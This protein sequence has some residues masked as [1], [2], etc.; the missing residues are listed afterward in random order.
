MAADPVRRGGGHGGVGLVREGG[1]FGVVDGSIRQVFEVY[2][3]L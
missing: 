3:R 1:S 2:V